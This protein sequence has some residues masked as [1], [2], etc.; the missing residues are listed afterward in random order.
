[1]EEEEAVVYLSRDHRVGFFFV[2][3]DYDTICNP[4][5]AFL[6]ALSLVPFLSI[7]AVLYVEECIF[8]RAVECCKLSLLEDKVFEAGFDLE[9]VLKSH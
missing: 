6:F 7:A 5:V 9:W 1:M 2:L 8:S 3:W 4:L